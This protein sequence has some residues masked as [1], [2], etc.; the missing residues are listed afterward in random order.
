[1]D[2]NNMANVSTLVERVDNMRRSRRRMPDKY[3]LGPSSMVPFVDSESWQERHARRKNEALKHVE[4]VRSWCNNH[5]WSFTV[6]NNGH[7]WIFIT[8]RKKM[9][10]WWPS[11]GKFVIGK[12]YEKGFHC[13]DYLQLLEALEAAL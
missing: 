13:H 11:S 3:K 10:Q 6:N 7:H 9:I 5:H 12:F 1:M 4:E 8:Q 2:T